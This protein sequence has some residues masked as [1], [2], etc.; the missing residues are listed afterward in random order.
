MPDTGDDHIGARIASLRKLSG[1]TQREFADVAFLSLGAVRKVEQGERLPTSGFLISAARVLRV[2][3]EELSG[4]PYKGES[5]ADRRVHAPIQGIRTAVRRYDLPS[6]VYAR[7]RPMP[8]LKA[9]VKTASEYR[10]EAKYARLGMLLPGLLEE[11]TAAVHLGEDEW[12]R[13]S[14]ARLLASCFYM[15]H[16]LAFRLGYPDLTAQLED[17]MRWAAGLADDPLMRAL[18]EWTHSYS[19][20]AFGDYD[21]ALRVLCAAREELYEDTSVT[22]PARTTMLGSIRLRESTIASFAQDADLTSLHI[23]EAGRLAEQIPGGRDRLYYHM[24]FGPANVSV[25]DVAAQVELKQPGEAVRRAAAVRFPADMAATR[26]GHHFVAV[27]RAHLDLDRR[28]DALKHL[29]QARAIAPEQTKF[30]PIAR[31]TVRMLTAK[32]RRTT[33]ELRAFTHWLGFQ[34]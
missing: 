6:D 16:G 1:Y 4:Q 25:H 31:E 8:E 10:K 33:E 28:E 13:A 11:L 18:A 19:F 5:E 24:T 12:T 15:A 22:G 30:H 32:C 21:G 7:P 17:R 9:D 3:V 34:A 2:T 26:Q 23:T 29:K 14:A 20:Q 27:A